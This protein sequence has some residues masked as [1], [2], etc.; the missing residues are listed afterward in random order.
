M[1]NRQIARLLRGLYLL[2]MVH[3]NATRGTTPKS[4]KNSVTRLDDYLD[5]IERRW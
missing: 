5:N 2:Y 1:T 4:F 3:H